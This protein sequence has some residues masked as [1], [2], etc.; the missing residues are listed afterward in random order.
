MKMGHHRRNA[1]PDDVRVCL[2]AYYRMLDA[3]KQLRS[4]LAEQGAPMVDRLGAAFVQEDI[5]DA[6]KNTHAWLS[7]HARKGGSSSG[8][9]QSPASPAGASMAQGCAAGMLTV[10]PVARAGQ[11]AANAITA[12]PLFPATE[13]RTSS[14]CGDPSK[15]QAA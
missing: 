5:E 3:M 14:G 15:T 1:N 10:G 4:E 2:D 11:Q 9:G 7:R 8:A 12:D 13:D 6:I